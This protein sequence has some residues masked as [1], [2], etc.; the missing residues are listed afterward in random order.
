MG[1]RRAVLSAWWTAQSFHPNRRA[2][3]S[4]LARNQNRDFA[5]L[6]KYRLNGGITSTNLAIQFIIDRRCRSATL[7]FGWNEQQS[8]FCWPYFGAVAPE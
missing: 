2:A 4:W 6:G 3:F 7:R 8:V 5:V 1:R